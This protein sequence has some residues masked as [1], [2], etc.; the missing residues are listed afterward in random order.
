MEN[1]LKSVNVY[2]KL[3]KAG[4]KERGYNLQIHSVNG[5]INGYRKI[6]WSSSPERITTDSQNLHF[7]TK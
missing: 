4:T 7:V 1:T 6:G 5:R 2:T 3:D